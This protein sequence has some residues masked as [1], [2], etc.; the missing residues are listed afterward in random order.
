MRKTI[1][2]AFAAVCSAV[3]W[4]QN[5][6]AVTSL[7]PVSG[8]TATTAVVSATVLNPV[9]GDTML[10]WVSMT[11]GAYQSDTLVI[12]ATTPVNVVI[13]ITGLTPATTYTQV[14]VH[15][16]LVQTNT[17]GTSA[18]PYASFM[19]LASPTSPQVSFL[20]PSLDPYSVRV[21]FNYNFGCTNATQT[22]L[23]WGLTPLLGTYAP[24]LFL[25]GTGDTAITISGLSPMT[26]VYYRIETI[27]TCAVSATAITQASTT[28]VPAP[29]GSCGVPMTT[30]HTVM[31]PFSVQS[32]S[33]VMGSTIT[34]VRLSATVAG[35]VYTDSIVG[36]FTQLVDTF[37][38][39]GLTGNTPVVYTIQFVN[40]AGSSSSCT[41]TVVTAPYPAPPQVVVG[42]PTG[43]S[44]CNA[45]MPVTVTAPLSGSVVRLFWKAHSQNTYDT[46]YSKIVCNP[47]ITG[48]Y[49]V[50][51]TPL[52]QE[53]SYHVRTEQFTVSENKGYSNTVS[54]A[55]LGGGSPSIEVIG[56]VLQTSTGFLI[57]IQGSGNGYVS[58]AV[59]EVRTPSGVMAA[60]PSFIVGSCFFSD[61]V[62][63][64]GLSACTPYELDMRIYSPGGEENDT[65]LV[66]TG[67]AGIEDIAVPHISVYP[68][69]TSEML[70]IAGIDDDCMIRIIDMHGS[71][72]HTQQGSGTVMIDVQTLPSGIYTAIVRDT[73]IRFI[74]K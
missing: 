7:N 4:G 56:E 1:L 62:A 54:I 37:S 42:Q 12:T 25:L 17:T 31:I 35:I 3:V 67:C 53:T 13:P 16:L 73:A 21:R 69:P 71:I 58:T 28:M 30:Y 47:C 20:T 41:S 39:S 52:L 8:I 9:G 19:T 57:P 55:T 22:R 15:A 66:R 46:L 63:V 59:A 50:E 24:D 6:T 32:G 45:Y 40:S 38:L 2:S 29:V 74:K 48:S 49:L 23:Q 68:N 51:V 60:S 14:R 10:V 27:S 18:P 5:P 34:K 72:V 65:E 70:W 36:S 43:M 44:S 26:P 64:V 61:T 11:G 33:A